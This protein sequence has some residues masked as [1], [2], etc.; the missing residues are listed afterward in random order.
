MSNLHIED[1]WN[2][3]VTIECELEN[4][5]Y[6][7][8]I[9]FLH[10]VDQLFS[11]YLPDSQVSRLRRGEIE[12]KEADQLVQQ[13]WQACLA[14]KEISDGAF[15]PWAVP[16][17]FDPSGYVKGWAADQVSENLIKQGAKHIQV[18]AGGD[19]SVRGGKDANTPWKL[20]VAHPS[21]KGEISKLYSITTGAIATSGSAE[22]GDHIIDP[23]SKTVAVG[24]RSATV[25]GPDA[26]IS[27]AL[28]TALVV[29]GRD[30]A[31]WFAK[32]ALSEYSC[33]VVDRHTDTS[34]EILRK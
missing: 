15:D 29:S 18:N 16:G 9:A 30:G 12:I 14:V 22:R 4:I 34:W 21:I 19:I 3:V 24:A 7:D 28:A 5:S 26:G 13:V 33:W 17:G 8:S 6:K 10:L 31:S 32:E 27:D 2:T 1:V 11:T 20:A 25:I 23:H